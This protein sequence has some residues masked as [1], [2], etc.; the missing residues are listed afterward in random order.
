MQLSREEF[1]ILDAAAQANFCLP[2]SLL[3]NPQSG[4]HFNKPDHHLTNEQLVDLLVFMQK[5]GDLAIYRHTEGMFPEFDVQTNVSLRAPNARVV[6][7]FTPIWESP[8]F[9][10]KAEIADDFHTAA[11]EKKKGTVGT[12]AID[13]L[14]FCATRQGAEKW[15]QTAQVDWSKYLDNL[16]RS[17]ADADLA[18]NQSLSLWRVAALSEQTLDAYFEWRTRWCANPDSRETSCFTRYHTER[19]APWK[20]TY[21]KT[22]PE[23][24]ECDFMEYTIH[25]TRMNKK[26]SIRHVEFWT[27]SWSEHHAMFDWC[28]H[29]VKDFPFAN[30]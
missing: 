13:A 20:A 1:W 11:E 4:F 30:D 3:N 19:I 2:L 9:Y 22:F 16:G 15:E 14:C 18:E 26:E 8:V 24:F 29:F 5:Q 6:I 12:K 21:W 27:Q 23:G 10:S 17:I 25:R 28:N 7:D